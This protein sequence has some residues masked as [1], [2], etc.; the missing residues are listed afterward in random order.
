MTK[1]RVGER[2]RECKVLQRKRIEGA[3]LI[4]IQVWAVKEAN[5]LLYKGSQE[6]ESLSPLTYPVF[7]SSGT[8]P[9]DLL[10]TYAC[11]RKGITDFFFEADSLAHSICLI[12][13]NHLF[14]RGPTHSPSFAAPKLAID[15]PPAELS[16]L[17]LSMACFM[18]DLSLPPAIT[19]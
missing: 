18:R 13:V 3:W 12:V 7:K 11:S 16:A 9:V 14:S 5:F 19:P 10:N 15:M 2:E 6:R 8:H 1:N 17:R 4:F